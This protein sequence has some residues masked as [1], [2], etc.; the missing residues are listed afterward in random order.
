MVTLEEAENL[1]KSFLSRYDLVTVDETDELWM[2]RYLNN[3]QEV[4]DG[5]PIT[6][7]KETGKVGYVLLPSDK[8]FELI[9]KTRRIKRIE[10]S[11]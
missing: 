9:E 3:N 1:L 2:F 8:G 11:N 6:V 7:D 10:K 4:M 5:P